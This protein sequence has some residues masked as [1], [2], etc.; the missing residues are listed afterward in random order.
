MDTIGEI[1]GAGLD[2]SERTRTAPA[3][4]TPDSPPADVGPKDC[5]IESTTPMTSMANYVMARF[6][7]NSDARDRSG[8]SERLNYYLRAQRC[9]FSEDQRR[10]LIDLFGGNRELVDHVFAPITAVKNRA[11]KAMLVDL[12][13]Q[14][15]DPLFHIEP[16]PSPEVPDEIAAKV[17]QDAILEINNLFMMFAQMGV[18]ELPP[19][20]EARVNDLV[21]GMT[22]RRYDDVTNAEESYAKVRAK[23]L[24]RK[25]W[26]V[27]EEG[28]FNEAFRDYI[29]NI[30]TYGTGVIVGPVVRSVAKNEC[31]RDRKTGVVKFVR[32]I[33]QIPVFESISPQ[34][35]YPAPD[36]KAIGDGPMCFV[37]K[38]SADSLWQ[39]VNGSKKADRTGSG[40]MDDI[41]TEMLHRHPRGG[42][43]LD[44]RN[45][46]HDRRFCENNGFTDQ[47]DC[48][49]EG[50][51]CFASVRGSELVSMGIIVNRDGKRIEVNSYYRTETIVID[52][53]VVYCRIYD[54]TADLP[55]SKGCMYTLPGSWW[56]EAIADKVAMCQTVMNNCVKSLLQNM[57]NSA[58]P[59]WWVSDVQRLADKSPNAL[60]IHSGKTIPFL[61]SLAGNSGAPIGAISVPST[62][63]EIL[64]TW[65]AMVRQADIDSGIPA[66]TEGQSAGAG[67]A[68]RTSSGLQT[69]VEQQ[70]R[71]MKMI[72]SDTDKNVISPIA[73]R[74]A[75]W[76]LLNDD[77]V[78]IRGDV[79]IRSVGLIGKALKA[80]RDSARVQLFNLALNSQVLQQ[81]I[82]VKGLTELFRPSLVDIDVNPDDVLPSKGRMEELEL[83]QGIQQVFQATQAS[84]GVQENAGGAGMSPGVEPVQQPEQQG[85]VAERRGVA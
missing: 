46:N 60:K 23:R 24:E 62:A 14:S 73:R 29:D 55:I 71:G 49:F 25:V 69:F 64:S 35:C 52:N 81:I 48:T 85:G 7:E 5:S 57:T 16:S 18:Q 32:K 59:V 38:Y 34:D 41:V 76:V 12:V 27:M 84:N 47:D 31:V 4:A 20:I 53:R 54:Q 56:G 9:Q 43:K 72:M 17:M 67:G 22:E 42:V 63:S 50:V 2:E 19:E 36:A 28:G 11:A 79:E 58:G 51:R 78:S 80:Q 75:D 44:I 15:G 68:L 70:M 10:T 39:F 26:D 66:Y 61:T 77:D 82:G 40:W 74:T 1:F 8:M 21:S 6:Q 13:N 65:Q 33:K 83:I 30:C 3:S 37:V 45:Y